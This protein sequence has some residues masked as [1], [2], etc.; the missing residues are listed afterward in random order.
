MC[1]ATRPRRARGCALLIA[2][3]LVAPLL[4]GCEDGSVSGGDGA[5]AP[6]SEQIPSEQPLCDIQAVFSKYNCTSCHDDTPDFNGAGLDLVS[7]GLAERL[8][9]RPSVNPSCAEN[10]VVSLDNPA[11]SLLLRSVA[12]ARY[13]DGANPECDLPIM[14]L[15]GD[16]RLDEDE[17]TCLENWVRSLEGPTEPV[18]PP[19]NGDAFTVLSKTKYIMHGG[20]ITADELDRVSDAEGNIINE[21]LQ[22]VVAEWMTTPE[23]FAKRRQFL[24]LTLQQDPADT[25]YFLQFR[26]TIGLTT[27]P[28]RDNLR[29]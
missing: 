4:S 11:A 20:A 26:N 22:A 7:E 12:P 8:I 10:V 29:L 13:A 23:F 19:L 1:R 9:N 18:D 21:A 15:V 27:A 2:A 14:P 5:G 25:N 6:S 24:R 3:S 28:L 16:A 17:V